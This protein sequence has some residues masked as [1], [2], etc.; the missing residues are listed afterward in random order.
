M[1]TKNYSK[2]II[3]LLV[4]ILGFLIFPNFDS[5]T[6]KYAKITKDNFYTLALKVKS[7]KLSEVEKSYLSF[8]FAAYSMN[9]SKA[10]NKYVNDLINE[11]KDLFKGLT[12]N[13][14]Y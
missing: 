7:S 4:L 5:I 8:A 13:I 2:T 11:G 14:K 3:I 9:P 1:N 10:Y 6:Y 12:N